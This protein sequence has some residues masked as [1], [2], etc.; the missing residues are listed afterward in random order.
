MA[1]FYVRNSLNYEK[2]VKFNI[3]L[4]YFVPKGYYGDHKWVLEIGTTYPDINGDR[5]IAKKIHN[6]SAENLDQVIE[7]GVAELCAQIDWSPLVQDKDAPYIDST[8]PEHGDTDVSIMTDIYITMKDDLPSAGMDLSNM[9]ITL[10]NSMQTFD[11]T[12]EVIIDG[13][14]FEYVLRWTPPTRVFDT[15]E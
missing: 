7:E 4:R 9:K 11:I 6:I 3:T 14:P 2:A 13:D 1:E 15:Y 5:I 8:V 12:S 10:N